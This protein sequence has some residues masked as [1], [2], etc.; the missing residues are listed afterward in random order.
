MV[1]KVKKGENL[2]K[3]NIEKV[4]ELLEGEKPITKKEACGILNIAYN[5]SRLQKIIN[6]HDEQAAYAKK[7]RK[8][9][10]NTPV[11]D[12]D[13]CYIVERVLNGDSYASISETTFRSIA[14]IKSVLEELNVPVRTR[15]TTE[16]KN[17]ELLPEASIK[18]DYIKEDLVFSARYGS[19][20]I[21][22]DNI[23]DDKFH[24]KVYS[25]YLL[26]NWQRRAIQPYYEL[27]DLT[28]IQKELGL[29]IKADRGLEP[30]YKG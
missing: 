1:V 25:I 4:I 16:Y 30:N 21:I 23:R 19:P 29:S 17:P 15:E 6:Q 18:E 12:I 5:T 11:S 3:D 2:S 24:G 27:G 7:R 8:E 22:M 20:A 13:K 26:G 14:K 10:R 28:Y 9:I